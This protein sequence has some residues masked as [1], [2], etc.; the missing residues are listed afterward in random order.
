MP[1]ER[2]K[3][4]RGF[5]GYYQVS[6][7]GRVKSLRR[8]REVYFPS[9]GTTVRMVKREQILKQ[10]VLFSSNKLFPDQPKKLC[11][12]TL[13][14]PVKQVFPMMVG[15]LVYAAFKHT[16]L[17]EKEDRILHKNDIGLDNRVGNLLLA[18]HTEQHKRYYVQKRMIS[19]FTTMSPAERKKYTSMAIEANQKKVGKYSV[20]GRRIRI[21]KSLKE[22]AVATGIS[23]ETISNA[24]AG[25]LLSAGGFIWR[26]GELPKKIDTRYYQ[27]SLHHRTIR[28]YQPVAQYSTSGNKRLATYESLQQAAR[29]HGHTSTR[30]ISDVLN[31][32]ANTAY[33]FAWKRLQRG[34]E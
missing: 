18:T 2:W 5:E 26:T 28:R 16:V 19:Y 34:E 30:Q 12:V 14:L 8:E 7:M 33:G 17:K 27:Q 4:I 23:L 11:R 10:T 9:R 6:N 32:R 15:R 21:Y 31:G 22:A 1:G 20:S 3:D 29:A 24:L 25:R 13:T